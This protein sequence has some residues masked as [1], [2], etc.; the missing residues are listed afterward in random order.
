MATDSAFETCVSS[1]KSYQDYHYSSNSVY[2]NSVK[3]PTLGTEHFQFQRYGFLDAK[4][5]CSQLIQL[6]KKF[7][8]L[9]NRSTTNT[10]E[11]LIDALSGLVQKPYTLL[12]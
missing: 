1:L 5:Q 11:V 2:N 9:K 12:T 7:F 8:H 6:E 4:A 3:C 10:G